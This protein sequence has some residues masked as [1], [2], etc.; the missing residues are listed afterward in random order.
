MSSKGTST[1]PAPTTG[2]AVANKTTTIMQETT[3]TRKRAQSGAKTVI[4]DICIETQPIDNLQTIAN[5]MYQD[6]KLQL[7]QSGYINSKTKET[8]IEKLTGMYEIIVRLSDTRQRLHTE[9]AKY[10]NLGAGGSVELEQVVT[11][12]KM[13]LE[14]VKSQNEIA[15]H[16]QK[17]ITSMKE[18]LE[19]IHNDT[20]RNKVTSDISYAQKAAQPKRDS[21]FQP[22]SVHSIIVSSMEL[23]DTSEA[24]IQKIRTAV[25][26]KVTGIRVDKMR[27]AR[28][29]KVVLGCETKEELSKLT[30]RLKASQPDLK[31]E[32]R[33]NKDPLVILKDV[34]TINNDDDILS[35]LKNQ[36][37]H[38][39]ADISDEDYRVSVKYRKRARNPH[40]NHV[41]LQVSPQVWQKLTAAGKLHVDLQRIIV[42]DQSPL[43]QCSRCLGFGH[44]RKLC[45]E[46]TD[47]CSHC[48]DP[49]LRKD[50][51]TFLAGDSATCRNCQLAKLDKLDHNSFDS[52]CPIRKKWDILARSSV[53]YC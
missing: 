52:G 47:L 21:K 37:R 22:Q 30:E 41:V 31:V 10:K 39:L 29:Q 19:S 11:D 16:T 45:K 28:D 48:T 38:L 51:P 2:S 9:V 46:T 8:V 27:K 15:K 24:V 14:E 40:I 4:K 49:H 18:M 7:E 34:L 1:K 44:G 20:N 13:I 35:A 32:E 6:A 17:E 50:C 36:N 25:D 53:A 43:I 3:D 33:T 42:Q 23:K 12:T 5:R 26:A